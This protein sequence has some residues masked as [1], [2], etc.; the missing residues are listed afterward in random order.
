MRSILLLEIAVVVITGC[1]SPAPEDACVK[2]ADTI[3]S[4]ADECGLDYQTSYDA[5]VEVFADGDCA[6]IDDIPDEEAFYDECLPTLKAVSCEQ[7]NASGI[8]FPKS[9]SL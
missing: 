1:S 3:A 4:K 2:L 7:L 5:A 9:C 8:E 6:A